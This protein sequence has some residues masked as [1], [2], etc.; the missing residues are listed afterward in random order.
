MGYYD[1]PEYSETEVDF[2]C[3]NE[4]CE[5]ENENVLAYYSGAEESTEVDCE[6]CGY[7]NTVS[8][9]SSGCICAGQ[10]YCRC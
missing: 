6:K 4:E 3:E 1:P 10:D 2:T 5:H 8:L 9:G 7:S